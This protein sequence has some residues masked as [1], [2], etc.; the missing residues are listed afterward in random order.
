MKDDFT[1]ST[2]R[3]EPHYSSVLMQQGRVQLD[4][5]WNE[6]IAIQAHL[7]HSTRPDMI[8]PSGAPEAQAGFALRVDADGTLHI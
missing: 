2:F 4:A 8:G 7:D 3:P 5:D 6:Q 1:R